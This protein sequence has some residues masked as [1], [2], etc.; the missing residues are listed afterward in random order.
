ML[1][2]SRFLELVSFIN[3]FKNHLLVLLNFL[4]FVLLYISVISALIFI[5]LFSSFLLLAL[6]LFIYF[7]C[8]LRWNL[9]FDLRLF[10]FLCIIINFPL[11]TGLAVSHTFWN[12]VISFSFSL[13]YFLHFL[14]GFLF[15]YCAMSFWSL[16]SHEKTAL[17]QIVPPPPTPNKKRRSSFMVQQFKDLGV[18]LGTSTCCS[19]GQK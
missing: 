19:Y 8:L 5:Y 6:G 12:V 1:V 14:W 10:S 11:T 15:Y 16:V 2:K 4:L 7:L 9:K 17:V 18:G 13:I 3:L